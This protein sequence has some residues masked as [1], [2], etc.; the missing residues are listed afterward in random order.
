MVSWL[1]I[2]L[3]RFRNLPVNSTPGQI[4]VDGRER[5]YRVYVPTSIDSAEPVPLLFVIHGGGGDAKSAEQIT[6]SGF[7]ALAETHGFIVV[8]PE[9]VDKHWNDGRNLD[10]TATQ[11]DIDD[12]GFFAALIDHMGEQYAI[13]RARVYATGISNGGFMSYRLACE[14]SDQITG[15]AAVTANLSEPLAA[16]CQP[17][18]PVSVLIINGTDDPLVPFEGGPVQVFRQTR[19]QIL[20]TEESVAF[21]RE[22]NGCEGDPI[23]ETLPD[24][25][26]DDG[27]R[28]R[29][30]TFT[31]CTS[32]RA[33]QLYVVEGGGHTWP[34]GSQYLHRWFV[35]RTS[36]DID[37]NA[38][39]WAFF[40]DQAGGE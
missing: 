8:Y 30:E 40:E 38:I 21:W 24:R 7:H 31:D 22:Q 16:T 28:V 4:T 13:D 2:D 23:V 3:I 9:G 32:G 14:L 34:G 6:H 35:G 18:Q 39:I 26:P 33:V 11:E 15:I 29:R 10:D 17:T 20:S 19:G 37:A 36:N 27:T 12:V 5:S 25:D 1:S